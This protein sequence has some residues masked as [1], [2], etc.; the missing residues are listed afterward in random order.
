MEKIKREGIARL[1]VRDVGVEALARILVG[2]NSYI[3]EFLPKD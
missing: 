2:E 1:N 3:G